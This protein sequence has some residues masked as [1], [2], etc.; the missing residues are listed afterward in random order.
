MPLDLSVLPFFE[1]C[2]N[3]AA[4]VSLILGVRAI[5]GGKRLLHKRLMLLAFTFSCLFLAAYLVYHFSG[6]PVRK[7]KG[8][9]TLR[10]LYLGV[11]LSHT[12]LAMVVLPLVLRTFYLAFKGRFEAHRKMAVWTLWVWLYVSV[13]GVLIYL[14][15]YPLGFGV[16]SK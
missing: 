7:F 4:V 6:V 9:S 14:T 8:P 15:I 13:T 5:R 12:L 11:L 1:A 2:C 3:S 10:W 16:M